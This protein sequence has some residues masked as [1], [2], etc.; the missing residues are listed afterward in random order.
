MTEKPSANVVTM[1]MDHAGMIH[2][3]SYMYSNS[4]SECEDL[5]QEINYQLIKSYPRFREESKL[6]TWVYK[7][8]LFTALAQI[9]KQQKDISYV[10]EIPEN[11]TPAEENHWEELMI[12]IKQ[13][14][15][16]DRSIIFLYLEDRS[17]KE[18]A[19]ILGITESNLGVKL[20]RIKK[21]LKNY[22][23]RS[24]VQ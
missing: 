20:N 24:S 8:A 2:K 18:M 11:A 7:V 3:L 22:F 19:E 4:D 10:S 9:R 12:A 15:E 14:P 23:N 21:K 13:L 16:I 5:K 17:Y 1:L 6:S